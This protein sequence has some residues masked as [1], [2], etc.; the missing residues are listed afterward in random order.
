MKIPNPLNEDEMVTALVESAWLVEFALTLQA[1]F[2]MTGWKTHM[3]QSGRV[4]WTCWSL[5]EEASTKRLP[6]SECLL[7]YGQKQ[8]INELLE[9]EHA[10]VALVSVCV[11]LNMVT[12]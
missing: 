4:A 9:V 11:Y 1:F 6:K 3:P 8:D 5:T 7:R 10:H 2:G 12:E